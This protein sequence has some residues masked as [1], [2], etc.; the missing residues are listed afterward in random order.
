[1][2]LASLFCSTSCAPRHRWYRLIAPC[3][4]GANL[5][6]CPSGKIALEGWEIKA[7]FCPWCAGADDVHAGDYL[8]LGSAAAAPNICSP[9]GAVYGRPLSCAPSE[10]QSVSEARRDS[11]RGSLSRT[12]STASM[13]AMGVGGPV[14]RGSERNMAINERIDDYLN[15]AG[16]KML[17]RSRSK[18]AEENG[19]MNGMIVDG[20][21]VKDVYSADGLVSRGWNKARK[22]TKDLTVLWR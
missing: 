21:S 4:P 10:V 14:A 9:V 8:L 11:R 22:K 15:G 5:A 3:A 16:Q 18:M 1:M 20:G 2:C 19:T 6:S 13:A 12:S 7:A 17:E